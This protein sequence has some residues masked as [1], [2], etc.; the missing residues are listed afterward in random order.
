ME[1]LYY[2]IS[3][4]TGCFVKDS[5][6]VPCIFGQTAEEAQKEFQIFISHNQ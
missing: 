5:G 4:G 2:C 3:L 1:D 6:I